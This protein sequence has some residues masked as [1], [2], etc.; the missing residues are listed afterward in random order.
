M[1][2]AKL[3]TIVC[4]VTEDDLGDDEIYIRYRLDEDAPDNKYS[5]HGAWSVHEMNDDDEGKRELPINFE[6]SFNTGVTFEVWDKDVGGW[7][8]DPDD[9]LGSFR[10]AASDADGGA[11]QYSADMSYDEAWYQV[12]YRVR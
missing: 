11:T 10:V 5:W 8:A 7:I 1:A 2:V 12:L 4:W 9:L 3:E 6:V